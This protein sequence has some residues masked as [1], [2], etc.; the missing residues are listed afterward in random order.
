MA[1]LRLKPSTQLLALVV[2]ALIFGTFAQI[3]LPTRIPW[4]EA[5]SDRVLTKALQAG[6]RL[7]STDQ[8]RAILADGHLI[9]FDARSLKDYEAGRIPGALPFPDTRR[10]EFY[11]DYEAVL[12]PDQPIVVYCS[13]RTCD[14]S[15]RLCLFLL[16]RGHSNVVLYLGGF[17]EWQAAGL[18]IER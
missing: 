13:G 2:L 16:E 8:L 11:P 14:E 17:S 7:A 15:L 4:R 3:A 12:T 1:R 6:I 10:M 5:W 9:L 18:D